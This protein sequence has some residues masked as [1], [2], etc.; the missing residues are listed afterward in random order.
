MAPPPSLQD[1]IKINPVTLSFSGDLEET[2]LDDYFTKSLR[3]VRMASLIAIFFYGAFG[4]LDSWLI[5]EMKHQL[6]FIRYAIFIPFALCFF[7]FSFSR[8]FKKYMQLSIAAVIM[9]AGLGIIAMIRIMP[10]TEI[11]SYYVGLILVFIFGYTF[12]KLRFIWATITGW[13][14]VIAYEI[15]AIWLIQS[16]ITVLINHNFFFL[17]SNILCMF[18]S[19]SIEL[20]SRKD[21]IQA[22]LLAAEKLKVDNSNRKLEK[23]VKDRTEQLVNANEDL[24]EEIVER[25]HA[26]E[27][28]KASEERYR[29]I[30]ESIE[31][32][33]FELDLSGNLMFFNDSLCNIVGYSREE[34]MGRNNRDYTSPETAKEM[35]GIFSEVYRTGISAKILAYDIINKNGDKVVVEVS[36]SLIRNSSG[37]PIGFRGVA[38]DATERKQAEAE[39]KKSKEAAE[40]AN[41]AK[42]EFL[43]NMSHELRTPLNHIMGFTELVVTKCFGELNEI[44]E[45]YLNDVLQSSRH[46]LSL[47]N[48]IL[49]ISR[50][51]EGR[52]EIK[53]SEVGVRSLM[54][55]SLLMIKEKAVKHGLKLSI[56]TDDL[57]PVIKADERKLKQI[58][59]NLLANAVK[60]TP[61]GG[62]LSMMARQVDPAVLPRHKIGDCHVGGNGHKFI[63][64]AISDTGIGIKSE[65]QDRIFNR[66]EQADGSLNR[67]YQGAGLG[68]T[69]SKD[70]VELHGGKIWVESEGEG[71][72]ST[73]GFVI[74]V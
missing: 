66:F 68:L 60:F 56:Y 71:K 63:E 61:D 19:Y 35:Y 11:Y 44:Q 29:T 24:K 2:F 1:E 62:N 38:R 39:Q 26:E 45:E 54:E 40:A 69:L 50:I 10:F 51:E 12:F 33:Y 41:R 65:D 64:F 18:A 46:L 4:I 52:M 37:E 27:A 20:Y 57:L 43:A 9:A 23:A 32:G 7:L 14:L 48:D 49:D 28:L 72:G 30:I 22:R 59:Y 6:W 8:H 36:T 47:I 17:S 55:Q 25:K 70:L 42:S 15:A 73:F 16:P 3:H 21:F 5:P 58:L 13:L 74:P 31:E 34:L 67:R 53:L